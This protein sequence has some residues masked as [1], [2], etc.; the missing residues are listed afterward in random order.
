MDGGKPRGQGA[1]SFVDGAGN[2]FIG[3]V[4][5]DDIDRYD[6]RVHIIKRDTAGVVTDVA[7]REPAQGKG[8]DCLIVQSGADILVG[9]FVH[10][11]DPHTELQALDSVLGVCVPYPAGHAQQGA[12]GAFLDGGSAGGGMTVAELL[13]A[14]QSGPVRDAFK[15]IVHEVTDAQ[16]ATEIANIVPKVQAAEEQLWEQ[17]STAPGAQHFQ[18]RMAQF[19]RDRAFEGDTAAEANEGGK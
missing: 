3:F 2:W 13:A 10:V 5:Y 12:P 15:G 8:D 11:G 18:D 19:D 9:L 17:G 14:L 7:I 6:G 16:V 1:A 4:E